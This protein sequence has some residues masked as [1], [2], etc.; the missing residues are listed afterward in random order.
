MKSIDDVLSD[1]PSL[2]ERLKSK[3]RKHSKKI[4]SAA[5]P[6]AYELLGQTSN[7]GLEPYAIPITIGMAATGV[8]ILSY[9]IYREYDPNALKKN[10]GSE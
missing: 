2:F 9:L 4:M 10:Q 3:F 5:G 8:S 7:A 1:E 6:T